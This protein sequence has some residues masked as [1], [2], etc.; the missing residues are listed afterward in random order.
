MSY[1]RFFPVLS[2]LFLATSSFALHLAAQDAPSV[3]EAARRAREQKQAASK[4]ATVV[5]NDTLS[6]ATATA[7]PV[8]NPF[9]SA[10]APSSESAESS[11]ENQPSAASKDDAETKAATDSLKEEIAKKQRAADFLQRE[12][13]LEQDNFYSN[14]DYQRDTAT[15][16]KLD[17][18]KAELKDKQDELAALKA[19]L[20]GLSGG[21]EPKESAP[22]NAPAT[23]VP[24]TPAPPQS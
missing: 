8:A 5:T 15:K 20:A 22:P 7:S 18:M 2:L 9:D 4:P 23:T 11:A 16:Q 14:P 24:A 21:E 13:A 10:P 12:I 3:A 17:S 1:K 6:P 19:K